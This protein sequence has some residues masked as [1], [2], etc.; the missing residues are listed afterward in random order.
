MFWRKTRYLTWNKYADIVTA[1]D[2]IAFAQNVREENI[3]RIPA[4]AQTL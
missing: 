2:E 4:L 3:K 1:W